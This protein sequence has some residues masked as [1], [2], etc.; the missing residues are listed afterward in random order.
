[1]LTF[2]FDFSEALAALDALEQAELTAQDWELIGA[3]AVLAILERTERGLNAYGLPFA[4]YATSTARGRVR[5][6][7]KASVVTLAYTGKMLGALTSSSIEGGVRL[8]FVT[9]AA[10][11]LAE[12]HIRGTRRMPA[13]NFLLVAPRTQTENQLAALAAKLLLRRFRAALVFHP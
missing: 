4:R 7:R 5:K 9:K 8:S 1:M 12:R 3:R 10:E 11:E 2:Q 6:G 13:R